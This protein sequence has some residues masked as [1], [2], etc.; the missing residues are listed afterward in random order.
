MKVRWR[1]IGLGIVAA[2]V[3]LPE[4]HS[5][6]ARRADPLGGVLVM[7]GLG[8]LVYGI[9]GFQLEKTVI[10]RRV[11]LLEAGR[12]VM[13]RKVVIGRGVSFEDLRRRHDAILI[14]TGVYKARDL[15]APGS[16]LSNIVPALTYLIASNRKG[17]GDAAP[18]AT[19][20]A[21]P[22]SRA[23]TQ[24]SSSSLA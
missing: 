21:S 19:C 1:R 14:A 6:T 10:K 23:I 16:G 3:L 5:A 8:A 18:T 20:A 4:S 7:A 24:A 11:E 2:L 12:V 9:T 13:H 17:I 22:I 15:R